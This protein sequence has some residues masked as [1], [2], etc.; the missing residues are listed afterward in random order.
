MTRRAEARTSPPGPA[1]SFSGELCFCPPAAGSGRETG[2]PPGG[3]ALASTRPFLGSAWEAVRRQRCSNCSHSF[4]P[5]PPP[6]QPALH[7][8][9]ELFSPPESSGPGGSRQ[10]S[11]L[12]CQGSW[13]MGL[14][15]PDRTLPAQLL[16]AGG[17]TAPTPS[18]LHSRGGPLFSALHLRREEAPGEPN[19][20]IIKDT[21]LGV[22]QTF[23]CPC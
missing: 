7:V 9:R 4:G 22:S 10:K 15:N 16:A 19:S 21:E 5:Q 1:Q 23:L 14:H 18:P 20:R 13:G 8:E 17:S 12:G 6:G 2:R 3:Q 11:Q